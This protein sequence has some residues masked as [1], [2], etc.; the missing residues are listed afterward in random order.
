MKIRHL[1][2]EDCLQ[3][4]GSWAAAQL[5]PGSAFT[6]TGFNGAV[7][8][9]ANHFTKTGDAAAS[10]AKLNQL[11]TSFELKNSSRRRQAHD[12]LA[13]Y[14]RWFTDSGVTV[15]SGWTNISL[16]LGND[17]QL[18]GRISRLDVVPGGYRGVLLETPIPADWRDQLRMPLIQLAL[19]ELFGRPVETISIGIQDINGDGLAAIS[20]SAETVEGAR[21]R[22][23]RLGAEIAAAVATIT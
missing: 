10:A 11:F 20:F 4:P 15:A 21:T 14:I 9:A 5:Q 12:Q 16:P 23:L 18:G 1:E 7:K 3:D 22:A 8:I 6:R 19:S 2:L 17:L 13:S